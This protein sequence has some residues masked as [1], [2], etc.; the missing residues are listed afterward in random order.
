MAK[1]VS[2]FGTPT[3][4]AAFDR[5]LE[6]THLPLARKIPGLRSLEVST[7]PVMTP[8]GP[9]PYHRV[10]VL[11][12]D[13]MADLQAGLASP[14]GQAAGADAMGLATGGVTLLVFDSREV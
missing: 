12:F 9:A 11:S 6:A 14:E 1:L 8:D 7:G 13:S 4:P 3:D 2:L 10:G 5:H